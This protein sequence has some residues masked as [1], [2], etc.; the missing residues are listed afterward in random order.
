MA[1]LYQSL[2][3]ELGWDIDQALLS[4]MHSDIEEKIKNLDE[5]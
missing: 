1:E 2:C 5:K 3:T 4:K